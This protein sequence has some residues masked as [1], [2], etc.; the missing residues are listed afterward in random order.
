VARASNAEEDVVPH[1][2]S[3][4]STALDGSTWEVI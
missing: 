1:T 3:G 4:P 2:L